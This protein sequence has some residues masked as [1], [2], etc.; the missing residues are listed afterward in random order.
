M[1]VSI[2]CTPRRGAEI[3]PPAWFSAILVLKPAQTQ[4]RTPATQSVLHSS[5]PAL[6]NQVLLRSLW[7]GA[8][9]SM[10]AAVSANALLQR[11]CIQLRAPPPWNDVRRARESARRAAA[12][13]GAAGSS[14]TR[15]LALLLLLHEN[16]QRRTSRCGWAAA[17]TSSR[18]GRVRSGRTRPLPPPGSIAH[19]PSGL[20]PGGADPLKAAALVEALDCA[21]AVCGLPRHASPGDGGLAGREGSC[22]SGARAAPHAE[23][24]YANAAAAAALGIPAGSQHGGGDGRRESGGSGRGSGGD[25]GAAGPLLLLLPPQAAASR[26]APG[27]PAA[28]HDAVEWRL[29]SGGGGGGGDGGSGDV[30]VADR[31]LVCPISAPSGAH[32]SAAPPPPADSGRHPACSRPAAPGLRLPDGSSDTHRCRPPAGPK[33]FLTGPPPR[34][35]HSGRR[36]RRRGPAV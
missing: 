8:G 6:L 34:P 35:P 1:W 16:L 9:S 3:Q 33:T 5:K 23:L 28:A 13:H 7:P 26:A 27:T 15:E 19:L 10:H 24:L 21:V 14:A 17:A 30:L 22:Q 36:A 32:R 18:H 29:S 2:L 25:S 20:L 31:L 11:S 12:E 4:V